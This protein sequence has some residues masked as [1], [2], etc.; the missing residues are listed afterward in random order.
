M[1]WLARRPQGCKAAHSTGLQL[2]LGMNRWALQPALLRNARHRGC[3]GH[4]GHSVRDVTRLVEC[5]TRTAATMMM[6]MKE[7]MEHDM[8][9]AATVVGA[10]IIQNMLRLARRP[11]E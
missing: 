2:M 1:T 3:Q 11:T 5:P 8:T 10:Y 4:E 6:M 9:E 7:N